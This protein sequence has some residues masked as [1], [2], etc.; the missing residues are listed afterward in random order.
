VC[1]DDCDKTAKTVNEIDTFNAMNAYCFDVVHLSCS[2]KE[3][4]LTIV[5]TD[6]TGEPTHPSLTVDNDTKNVI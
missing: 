6:Y 4:A 1:F 3:A 2:Q 5:T